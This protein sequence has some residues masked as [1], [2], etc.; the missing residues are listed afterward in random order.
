MATGVGQDH[1][2]ELLLVQVVSVV[3]LASLWRS[4]AA[5]GPLEQA[6]ASASGAV[7]DAV[8]RR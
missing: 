3:L 1:P 2:V 8:A 4:G 7:R 5:R 6:V